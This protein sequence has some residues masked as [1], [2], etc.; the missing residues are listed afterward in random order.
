MGN[1]K[2]RYGQALSIQWL[3]FTMDRMMK[4]INRESYV[5][6]QLIG[7]AKSIDGND[8]INSLYLGCEITINFLLPFSIELALKAMLENEGINPKKIHGI[9]DLYE[10]LP[11]NIKR[12]LNNDFLFVKEI[13]NIAF[14]DL[15]KIHNK[16]FIEWRY[17]DNTSINNMHKAELQYALC[18]IL[19]IYNS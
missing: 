2:L 7:D 12:D 11:S 18:T 1:E 13:K 14:D 4:D 9:Y 17:L 15:L 6:K 10:K 5:T 8:G 19:D 16:D 3:T